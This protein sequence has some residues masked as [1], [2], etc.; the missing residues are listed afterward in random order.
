MGKFLFV[1]LTMAISFDMEAVQILGEGLGLKKTTDFL[2]NSDKISEVL[3]VR[4]LNCSLLADAELQSESS[5][6]ER[7]LSK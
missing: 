2:S 5:E 7:T 4:E 6:T 1:C 3:H